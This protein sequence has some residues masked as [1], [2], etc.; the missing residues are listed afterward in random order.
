[1]HT[2]ILRHSIKKREAKRFVPDVM[3]PFRAH[4]LVETVQCGEVRVSEQGGTCS[5]LFQVL[6]RL[7]IPQSVKQELQLQHSLQP[8][9]LRLLPLQLLPPGRLLHCFLNLQGNGEGV[10]T[11]LWPQ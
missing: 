4:E 2:I 1:M 11:A 6:P 3:V 9:L 10:V 8:P 5:G 7:L